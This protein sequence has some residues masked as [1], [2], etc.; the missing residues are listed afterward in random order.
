MFYLHKCMLALFVFD[1]VQTYFLSM[2]L[3][4]R[5]TCKSSLCHGLAEGKQF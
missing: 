3:R 5:D 2:S 1:L 4:S